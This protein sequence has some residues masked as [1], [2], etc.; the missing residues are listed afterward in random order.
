MSDLRNLLG[1]SISRPERNWI[2]CDWNSSTFSTE[3]KIKIP[4]ISNSNHIEI[5]TKQK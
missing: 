5:K 4:A 3:L 1:H 2:V